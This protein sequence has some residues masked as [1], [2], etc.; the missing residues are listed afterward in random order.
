MKYVQILSMICLGVLLSSC[1]SLE[2]GTGITI[3]G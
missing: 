2:V 1:V 3:G